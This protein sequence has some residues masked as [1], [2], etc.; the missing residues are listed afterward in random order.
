[1]LILKRLLTTSCTLLDTS[2]KNYYKIIAPSTFETKKC[3]SYNE[4]HSSTTTEITATSTA[5]VAD[6]VEDEL[7][8]THK[9]KRKFIS[10]YKR[11]THPTSVPL[12]K[13]FSN[14]FPLSINESFEDYKYRNNPLKFQHDLLSILPFYPTPDPQVKTK[15]G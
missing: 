13:I 14:N 12:S 3:E 2:P 10:T 8:I 11:S 1:M 6:T 15:E 5:T 4:K 9:T 7:T